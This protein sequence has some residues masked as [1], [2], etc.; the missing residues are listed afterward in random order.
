MREPER[1]AEMQKRL[2]IPVECYRITRDELISL[3]VKLG[4]PRRKWYDRW[5]RTLLRW[6]RR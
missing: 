1:E 6:V 5:W 2:G 4:I 3:C